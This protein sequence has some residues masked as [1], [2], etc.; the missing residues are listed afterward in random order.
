M[1][2]HL[3]RTLKIVHSDLFILR[4]CLRPRDG[5][6]CPQDHRAGVQPGPPP[7]VTLFLRHYTTSYLEKCCSTHRRTNS[8]KTVP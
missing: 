1:Y 5:K 7:H 3:E 8:Y 4:G 2:I 6:W